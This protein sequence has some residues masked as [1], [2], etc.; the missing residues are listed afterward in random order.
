[1]GECFSA[2]F[3][4]LWL[5]LFEGPHFGQQ[6]PPSGRPHRLCLLSLCASWNLD[7]YFSWIH[8]CP[9]PSSTPC[10]SSPSRTAA[11]SISL[12]TYGFQL[13]LLLAPGNSPFF[14]EDLTMHLK[15]FYIW[16][17]E[18]FIAGAYECVCHLSLL[19]CCNERLLSKCNS[20]FNKQKENK[21]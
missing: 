4:P 12:L 3:P 15:K 19:S 2:H 6:P 11:P 17:F 16:H 8:T 20:A 1:M 21:I 14:I 7:P 5:Q 13:L 18:V 9:T 10:P